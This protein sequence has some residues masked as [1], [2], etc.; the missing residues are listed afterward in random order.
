MSGISPLQQPKPLNKLA[1]EHLR[2]LILSG[3]LGAETVYSEI[4]LAE[5]LGVSRTPVREALLELSS[6]GFVTFLPRKGIK[7][8]YFTTRDVEEVFELRSLVELRAV[9]KAAVRAGEG[10]I[11]ELEDALAENERG[12]REENHEIFLEGDRRFHSTIARLVDN[13]R[14]LAALENLRDMVHMMS[15][16]AVSRHERMP[17]VVDE[18]RRT[19][20]AIREGDVE[21]ARAAMSAHMDASEQAV[22]QGHRVLAEEAAER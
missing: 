2:T 1:Y 3:E 8:N 21:S 17:Q 16:Q 7:V 15:M 11:A 13:S 9:E 19:L 12:A 10:D 14:L 22:L 5:Q 18:H 4:A 6:Q 20:L